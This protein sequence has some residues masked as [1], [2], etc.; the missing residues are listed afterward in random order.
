MVGIG[1]ASLDLL[2][3]MPRFPAPNSKNRVTDVSIQGGGAAATACVA[4]ARLGARA[5]FAGVV[6]DDD[7][8]RAILRGLE[9]EGVD[10]SRVVV[11]TGRRSPFSFVAVNAGDASRTVFHAPGD[12]PPLAPGDIDDAIFDGA[13]VVLI[14]GRQREAQLAAAARA[15]RAGAEVLLDCER[16]GDGGRALAAAS[17]VVVASAGVVDELG[18]DAEAA[19]DALAALG[20]RWVVVTL[21]EEG[22]IGRAGG[23][24]LEQPAF[25][26]DA[27]DTTGCGDAYHGAFAVGMLRGLDLAGCMELAS[28]TAALKCRALGGR[29]GLPRA[30]EVDDFLARARR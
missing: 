14:D 4:A 9:E 28:A 2:G 30:G 1:L 7:L 21:G 20:P 3:S 29:D 6:G 22:S 23:P 27:V 11:A 16:L 19:L 25:R 24:I 8:G 18:G 15:R 5:A 10:V 12:L 13:G 17:D 26:V